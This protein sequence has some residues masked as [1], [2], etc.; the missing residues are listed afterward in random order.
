MKF[1]TKKFDKEIVFYEKPGCSGNKKQKELLKNHGVEFNVKSILDTKW[2][3][4]QL[5]IFFM[6]LDKEMCINTSAP[7]IKNGQ[8]DLDALSKDD[9][10]SLMIKDPILIKR[11]LIQIDEHCICS[12]DIDKINALLGTSINTD[13]TI[14]RCLSSEPCKSV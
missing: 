5:Q 8:I 13:K 10:I 3:K 9:M 1:S 6:G 12:F 4:D 7:Q 2:T 11:P 14:N